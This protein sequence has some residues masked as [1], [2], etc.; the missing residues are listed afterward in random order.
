MCRGRKLVIRREA[1]VTLPVSIMT[2]IEL[3]SLASSNARLSSFTVRGRKAFRLSGRFMVICLGQK[4]SRSVSRE[5][6]R[7]TR[8]HSQGSA[9]CKQ[10]AECDHGRTLVEGTIRKNL[11]RTAGSDDAGK[12]GYT[13]AMPSPTAFS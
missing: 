3:S 1:S 5:I 8:K 11:T 7:G 10:L 9:F 6:S 13:L 12:C 4:E 2:P